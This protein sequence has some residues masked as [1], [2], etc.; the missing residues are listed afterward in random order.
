VVLDQV[1][2]PYTQQVELHVVSKCLG[3]FNAERE[4]KRSE[5]QSQKNFEELEGGG[6]SSLH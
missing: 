4:D 5:R 3:F 1:S 2:R 6:T